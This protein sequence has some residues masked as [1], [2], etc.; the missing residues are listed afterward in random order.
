MCTSIR[1][2]SEGGKET[3]PSVAW[4]TLPSVLEGWKTLF[5]FYPSWYVW[6]PPAQAASFWVASRVR[7]G[8]EACQNRSHRGDGDVSPRGQRIQG[9]FSNTCKTASLEERYLLLYGIEN[10]TFPITHHKEAQSPFYY[11]PHRTTFSIT[12]YRE[13]QS[14]QRTTFSNVQSWME[15]S[16]D[17]GGC[18]LIQ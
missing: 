5:L 9:L 11:M 14:P 15:K 8:L 16:L 7:R 2:P 12:C 17:P 13:P 10:H 18:S 6:L 1:W 4:V 3:Q